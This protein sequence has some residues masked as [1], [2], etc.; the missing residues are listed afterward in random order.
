MTFL[1]QGS[2][3]GSCVTR[4]RSRRETFLV[5]QL[6]FGIQRKS[7]VFDERIFETTRL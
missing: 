1:M 4:L 3:H 5:S 7:I 6:A 2:Q